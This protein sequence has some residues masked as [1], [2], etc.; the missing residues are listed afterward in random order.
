MTASRD[1]FVEGVLQGNNRS[2]GASLL[3]GAL[4]P[5]SWLHQI[6]LEAYLLPYKTGIRKRFRLV[7]ANGEPV[8]AIAIGN[9]S[10]GGTGKTPMAHLVAGYLS[11]AGYRV[12]L[13]SRGHGGSGESGRTPRIVSDGER[14]LMTPETAGDEP[15]LLAKFLPS[16]PVI[17]GRDRRESGRLAVSTF[18]PDV[19]VLDD[20]LQY[21]Q[22]H[23]D[24]DIVLLDARRPFDNGFVLPRGLLREPPS[25]LKR[26]GAVVLTRADRVPADLLARNVEQAQ[27]LAPAAA[28]FTATHAPVGWVRA[29]DEALLPLGALSQQDAVAFS[30]IADGRAFAQSVLSLGV[31]ITATHDFGDHHV[32]TN[33]DIASLGLSKSAKIVVT[34]EKDLVKVAPLWPPEGP[35]LYALRIGMVLR[36]EARFFARLD[37]IL[38]RE[39]SLKCPNQ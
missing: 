4:T 1:R 17:V 7:G 37:T 14:V 10:S 32:Y 38:T 24:L 29:S 25:H 13:L 5:F 35:E 11:R 6:G 12:T 15:V 33:K 9:L 30:G 21:W 20:A 39:K 34:T 18:A 28:V 2:V 22:I 23:R 27:R 8:P 3:R 16:V 19:I 26:A 31:L 36:N